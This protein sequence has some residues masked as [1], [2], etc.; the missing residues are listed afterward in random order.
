MVGYQTGYNSNECMDSVCIGNYA[1]YHQNE[2][3]QNVCIGHSANYQSKFDY[4]VE[5]NVPDGTVEVA[6]SVDTVA[7]GNI[8]V[9]EYAMSVQ[10]FL[11]NEY[12][13]TYVSSTRVL[14]V[15]TDADTFGVRFDPKQLCG[16]RV[17]KNT[18]PRMVTTYHVTRSADDQNLGETTSSCCEISLKDSAVGPVYT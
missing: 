17:H 13:D 18:D 7:H 9:N 10:A 6:C 14:N 11:Y 15:N 3:T 8:V 2:G 1:G 12:V 4:V 16:F 5:A